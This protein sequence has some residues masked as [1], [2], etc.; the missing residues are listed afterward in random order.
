MT[1]RCGPIEVSG[2]LSQ[3]VHCL[4]QWNKYACS[5]RRKKKKE[6]Q[7]ERNERSIGKRKK[8]ER[9]VKPCLFL[10]VFHIKYSYYIPQFSVIVPYT[11]EVAYY[12]FPEAFGFRMIFFDFK[13]G[14]KKK[15]RR[16]SL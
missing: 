10:L 9:K 15:K 1:E 2:K 11:S 7:K 4:L 13:K 16:Y 8:K 3:L 5:N 6:G 14:K 12:I